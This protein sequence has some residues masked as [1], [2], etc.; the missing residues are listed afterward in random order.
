M[1]STPTPPS[2]MDRLTE[3]AAEAAYENRRMDHDGKHWALL[4]LQRPT[5]W[6]V[7]QTRQDARAAVG[8]IL[9]T[10]AAEGWRAVPEVA[11]EG[12]QRAL[13][14]AFLDGT[15]SGLIENQGAI[16]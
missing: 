11:T 10:L 12:M 7:I 13:K 1:T 16:E 2:L 8:A 3:A 14:V 5:P 9:S 15:Y 4:V 6:E